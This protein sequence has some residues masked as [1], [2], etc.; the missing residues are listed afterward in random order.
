[1]QEVYSN[2]KVLNFLMRLK[3]EG[4]IP[5]IFGRLVGVLWNPFKFAK[6]AL[7]WNF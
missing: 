5:G 3:N 6:Y 4:K 7:Q 1:M 2:N